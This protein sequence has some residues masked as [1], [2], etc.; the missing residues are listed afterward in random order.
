MSDKYK[1][2]DRVLWID[3]ETGEETSGWRVVDA[4][5]DDGVYDPRDIYVIANDDS[6]EWYFVLVEEW[7]TPTESGREVIN[8]TYDTLDEALVAAREHLEKERESFSSAI[9]LKAT[10][11]EKCGELSY[12][13]TPGE[14]QDDEWYDCVKVVPIAYDLRPI[15]G[16]VPEIP[17]GLKWK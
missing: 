1:V 12:V 14:G 16:Y 15:T 7:L 6:R 17:K 4:P 11:P 5:E 8:T 2:G 10:N 3:P 13:M 9:R